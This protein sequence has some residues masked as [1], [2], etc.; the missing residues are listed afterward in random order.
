MTVKSKAELMARY[1]TVGGFALGSFGV[2]GYISKLLSTFT[3]GIIMNIG[4]V[5]VVFG[6]LLSMTE[7]I[8]ED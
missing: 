3:S 1:L 4:I 7:K 8:D 2:G 6:I 5:L